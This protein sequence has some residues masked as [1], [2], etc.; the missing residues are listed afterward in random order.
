MSS[1]VKVSLANRLKRLQKETQS[2]IQHRQ[3]P[4]DEVTL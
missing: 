4:A 2:G 1:A 3:V